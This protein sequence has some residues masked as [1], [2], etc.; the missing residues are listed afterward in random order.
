MA[1]T[2][3]PPSLEALAGAPLSPFLPITR[4]ADSRQYPAN[5]KNR[6]FLCFVFGHHFPYGMCSKR[7]GPCRFSWLEPS[8]CGM[9]EKMGDLDKKTKKK[10]MKKHFRPHFFRKRRVKLGLGGMNFVASRVAGSAG[11]LSFLCYPTPVTYPLS[12]RIVMINKR[13]PTWKFRGKVGGG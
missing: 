13:N 11:P 5:A 3:A 10:T 6:G 2:M 4:Q 7:G 8:N 12:T 9:L 1:K